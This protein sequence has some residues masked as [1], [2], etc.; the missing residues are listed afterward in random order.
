VD[1]TTAPASLALKPGD[2]LPYLTG[3]V[4]LDYTPTADRGADTYAY[5]TVLALA[6]D[7]ALPYIVWRVIASPHGMPTLDRNGAL[8]LL[9]LERGD[10]C[11]TLA[12]ALDV[13]RD[14]GGVA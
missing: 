6:P 2:A 5:G 10:Y 1:T 14:R 3:T 8:H 4:V 13:Y 11:S 7:D 12:E 9:V